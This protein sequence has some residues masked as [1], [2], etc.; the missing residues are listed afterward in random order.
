MERELTGGKGGEAVAREKKGARSGLF[1][2][3]GITESGR[4]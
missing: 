4:K 3:F 1:F 2:F